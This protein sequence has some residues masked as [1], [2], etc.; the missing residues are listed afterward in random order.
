MRVGGKEQSVK[1]F[2]SSGCKV[3]WLLN[4]NSGS[5]NRKEGM[6]LRHKVNFQ[7]PT[8]SVFLYILVLRDIHGLLPVILFL[9]LESARK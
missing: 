4:W 5:V 3:F 2:S 8:D 7:S 9:R 1:L 6:D